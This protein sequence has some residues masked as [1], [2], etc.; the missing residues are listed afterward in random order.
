MD[1]ILTNGKIYTMDKN[2]TVAEA[3]AVEDHIIR[4]VGS[5]EEMLKL[6]KDNTIIYDLEGKTLLPGFNDSHMH[7]VNYGYSLTQVNL[8][9]ISSIEELNKR[10]SYFIDENK[11]EEGRWI[12]GR[13]WNQDYFTG[14]KR[15]P[16]RYDLDKISATNPIVVT[17]ACGHVVVVNSKALEVL[18]I[19]K[20]TEQI[21]GGQ[22]DLDENGEPTGVF[23]ENAVG[24]VYDNL[25]TPTIE[26]IKDMM[27]NAI[28]DMNKAGITSVGTDDFE[29]LPDRNYENIL[30]AYKELKEENKLN[31]RIYEQCLLSNID[32]LQ[33]FIDKGYRTSMGDNLFKIGPLK[34]LIDGS[35]GAR[36]AALMKPY[37]DDPN[38]VGI[39]TATDKELYN[40][41]DLAHRN[42]IQVAIHGI[43][44]KAMYMAFSAI[45]KSL[46]NSP[47]ENHRHGIVHC[48]ITDEYLLD[49]FKELN[50]IAYIQPIF[51]DYDWK[52]VRDRVGEAREKTSYNWKT[53]VNKG[54]AITCGSDSP[55]ETFDVMKGIYEAVTRKDLDGN[56]KDGW[57]PEQKLTVDEAVYGYTMGGAYASFE[58]DIKGSLE[59]DKLAD[60]VLLSEDIFNIDEEDIKNV[61]IHMT[62][63]GGKIV[64]I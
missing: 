45:E 26:E 53:M 33:G 16:S 14:E 30:K 21:E 2:R 42:N 24:L 62:I 3:M 59:V 11:I 18:N 52:I 35:L 36:T 58:E 23:R 56:P 10:V 49:K 27:R 60:M 50:A 8:I 63:L 28:R 22:F 13:G 47:K 12:R 41:V 17:R 19:G 61:D 6:K 25:P 55:V 34:L 37:S 46:K 43:G 44:D 57:L 64:Y 51:L 7:L 48:Q 40:L 4:A 32:K 1:L 15:F 5:T 54:V 29:A 39:T 31:I 9:G 38:T 20:E